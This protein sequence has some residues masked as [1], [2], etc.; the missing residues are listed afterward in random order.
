LPILVGSVLNKL[1]GRLGKERLDNY[2]KVKVKFKVAAIK[3]SVSKA[4][5]KEL[6]FSEIKTKGFKCLFFVNVSSFY[7]SAKVYYET[8]TITII[9]CMSYANTEEL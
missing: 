3:A 7:L 5:C 1:D 8:R 4:L 6:F 9:W 2:I